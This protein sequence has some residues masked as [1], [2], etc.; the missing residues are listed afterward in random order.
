MTYVI[1]TNINI[2]FAASDFR[3]FMLSLAPYSAK[4]LSLKKPV[5][6]PQKVVDNL[7]KYLKIKENYNGCIK[8]PLMSAI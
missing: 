1:K 8:L 2:N 6:H 4:K 7:H 3:V 5:N